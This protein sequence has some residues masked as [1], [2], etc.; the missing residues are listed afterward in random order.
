MI[1]ETDKQHL[2][3]CVE[4]AKQALDAGDEPFG[5]VLVSPSGEV[6]FEDHNHASSGD[7]TRHPEFAIAR[8]AANNVPAAERAACTVYT[9]GEHCSMC[10]SAHGWVGLG[11]IVYACSSTQYRQWLQE[12]GVAPTS[13]VRPLAIA[14]VVD[15]LAVEG[16]VPEFAEQVRLLHQERMRR[17]AQAR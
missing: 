5:S 7:R 2:A 1:T 17:R 14:E 9:S 4:L 8:W 13:K 3:R 15:G 6:L 10:A 11:R 12:W 16:P